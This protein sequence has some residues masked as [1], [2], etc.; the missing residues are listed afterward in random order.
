MLHVDKGQPGVYEFPG[1]DVPT[2][3]NGQVVMVGFTVDIPQ[4][5]REKKFTITADDH[6]F[7]PSSISVK[8]GDKVKLTFS[9]NDPEIYYGGL[10][11]KS[12]YFTITY[13]KSD[14]EESKMVEFT[15]D[16]SFT[17]TSYWPATNAIKAT[18]KVDVQ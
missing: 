7:D 16:D 9:F 17:F 5:V 11:V 15:A 2:Q 1:P 13:R 14:N 12:E 8:K 6:M 4:P 3:E 18:G 10:D